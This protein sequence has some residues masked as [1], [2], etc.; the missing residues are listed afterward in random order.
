MKEHVQKNH[1]HIPCSFAYKTVCVHD[2]FNKPIVIY[3]G[4]NDAYELIKPIFKEYKYCKK[5]IKKH[6]NKNLV[7]TEE[8]E[9]YFKKV[10]IV[11]FAE[12]LLIMTMKKLVIIVI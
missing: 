5:I 8:E 2:R 7:M 12:S 6:F 9:I 3:R 1:D 10:I 4:K 11:G